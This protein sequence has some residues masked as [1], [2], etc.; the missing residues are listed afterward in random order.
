MLVPFEINDKVSQ[1]LALKLSNDNDKCT[2]TNVLSLAVSEF[3]AMYKGSVSTRRITSL[4]VGT[5]SIQ[6]FVKFL[7]Q[8]TYLIWKKK[9][10]H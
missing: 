5:K 8:K 10:P 1:N 7:L 6:T 4:L 2:M 3:M 9:L